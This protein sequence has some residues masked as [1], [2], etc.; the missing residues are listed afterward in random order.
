MTKSVLDAIKLQ[1]ELYARLAR[2]GEDWS[3]SNIPLRSA[4][5]GHKTL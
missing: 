2:R 5:H 4:R 1:A 3:A